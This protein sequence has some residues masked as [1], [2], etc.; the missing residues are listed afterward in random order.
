[1]PYWR[2]PE[3]QFSWFSM[4]SEN[5]AP[6]GTR[7]PYYSGMIDPRNA[8]IAGTR[9]TSDAE[10]ARQVARKDAPQ[11]VLPRLPRHIFSPYTESF[12]PT[13]SP[14]PRH[15]EADIADDFSLESM[16][17][18][19]R[20]NCW[21]PEEKKTTHDVSVQTANVSTTAPGTALESL[22]ERTLRS[23]NQN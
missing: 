20:Q 15:L 9:I 3:S 14:T 10:M 21:I 8:Q 11:P 2:D 19:F 12:S 22:Q 18:E 4:T 1:M 7:T 16:P 13:H 17:E 5:I 23:T 6:L